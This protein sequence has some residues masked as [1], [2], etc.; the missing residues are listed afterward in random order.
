MKNNEV[1]ISAIFAVAENGVIGRHNEIP[2]YLP[3][4]FKYFKQMTVGSPI[5]MGRKTFDSIGRPLPKRHNIIISNN[6]S[7]SIAGCSV[8]HSL[9]QAIGLAKAENP[10]EIFIAGGATLYVAAMEYL[11]RIYR[12]IVH[13]SPIGDAF[14]S[15]S[16]E[17]DWAIL[18][19]N[20][21]PADNK[22]LVPFSFQVLERK[23]R[24]NKGKEII[25]G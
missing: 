7:L 4:D 1:T 24:S 20:Y 16:N 14:F 13:I 5:I 19:S 10:K 21:H 22:N 18:S 25:A 12:T 8:V 2:W 17:S 9:E 15:I 3:A 11:D 23:K 6:R